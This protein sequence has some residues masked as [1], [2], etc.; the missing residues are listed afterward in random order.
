MTCTPPN[1]I[2]P[3][4]SLDG[5]LVGGL[6][7]K[8]STRR[9]STMPRLRATR[10]SAVDR[11]SQAKDTSLSSSLPRQQPLTF[12]VPAC[13][14][15]AAGSW[16]GYDTT[17]YVALHIRGRQ[18]VRMPEPTGAQ[19]RSEA[20]RC[21]YR[22]CGRRLCNAR[23]SYFHRCMLVHAEQGGGDRSATAPLRGCSDTEPRSEFDR[24]V[25]GC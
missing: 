14:R 10:W 16:R 19:L 17:A 4:R 8:A 15:P 11:H 7:L 20:A 12:L 9:L 1:V 13:M 25:R 24:R 2:C 23:G 5:E 21:V 3:G 6:Q 18:S 22:P